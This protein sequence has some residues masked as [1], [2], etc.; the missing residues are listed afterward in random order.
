LSY[1]DYQYAVGEQIVIPWIRKRVPIDGSTVADF[2]AHAGG[3][4]DAF[5]AAGASSGMGYEINEDIVRASRFRDDEDFRL[6]VADL[7]T[8]DPSELSY[9]LIVLHDVLEH[10]PAVSAVLAAAAQ[11][12]APRGRIFVSFPPYYSMV[13][14]H[15]HLARGWARILPWIHY[16][17][18]RLFFRVARPSDNEYMTETDSLDDMVSV[19][20]TR[21]TLRKA[22]RAFA[23]AGLAVIDR[24]HFLSRP[25]YTIRYG[26]P[27]V[28]ARRV[29][30]IPVLR[31]AVVNG[32]F[33]LLAAR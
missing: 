22:E 14:G 21:L 19:R 6:E 31:E 18:E 8:F 25:E 16:L 32:A 30:R 2:G 24:E 11:S 7:A 20:S 5:R 29:G 23:D 28:T 26:W 27:T 12:L 33:Y 9:E 1:Y 15:Q 4:L 13:G 3:V 17:P 10:V